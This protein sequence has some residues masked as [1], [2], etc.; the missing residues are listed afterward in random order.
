M[1]KL[2]KHAEF[3]T[4]LHSVVTKQ[5]AEAQKNISGEPGKDIKSESVGSEHENH[6]KNS[7]KTEGLPQGY[8][9]EP[10]KDKSEPVA[11]AKSASDLGEEIL[12]IIRKHADAQEGIKGE[13]GKDVPAESVSE[14]HEDFDKNKVKPEDNKPQE[15]SQEPSKDKSEPVA[16]AKKAEDASEVDQLAAKVASYELG[17]Q[18]AAALLKTAAEYQVTDEASL[19]KEA[20]RRDFDLLISEAAARLG[21]KQAGSVEAEK[22][23]E[24]EAEAAGAAYFEEVLKQA[25]LEEA[26]AENESLKA[27]LAE[28]EKAQTKQAEQAASEQA[29][30]E[31][32]EKVAEIVLNKLKETPVQD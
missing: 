11:S 20:G 2:N 8:S 9:Q 29:K 18:F 14:K 17:R 16:K 31:L 4:Q 10:S 30:L 21:N 15:H 23:A 32:A 22:L 6:D 28:F 24:A 1:G 7:I 19:Q 13:P 27:K 5:A 12:S 3:L 26:I 25:A